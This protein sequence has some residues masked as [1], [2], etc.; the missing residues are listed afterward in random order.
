[1]AAK[2][3]S[4]GAVKFKFTSNYRVREDGSSGAESDVV[5][6]VLSGKIDMAWV[7]ARA[8]PGFDAL[9][10]PLLVDSYDLQATVFDAGVPARMLAD[11]HDAGLVGIAVLPGP[12][13]KVTGVNHPFLVPSDFDGQVVAGDV[14]PLGEATMRALGA[15]PVP[16]AGGQ[17]L[18]GLDAVE[19]HLGAI[20]G[21]GYHAIA[22][23]VTVNLNLWPRPLVVIMNRDV[24]A[25]LTTDQQQALMT[26][27]VQSVSSAMSDSRN[28]DAAVTPAIC[29]AQIAKVEASDSNLSDIQAALR[30]VYDNLE[31]DPRTAAYLAEIR[32][33]KEKLHAP[34]ATVVC[35]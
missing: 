29:K 9:L 20:A 13:R 11:L 28:E 12:M 35:P 26:A 27:G 8:L 4:A 23:S 5:A 34:P 18:D 24:F 25:R 3:T 7:G 16:G 2:Q 15:R 17:S 14:N 32:A 6:D 33:L 31:A 30:P 1:V 21:N 22:N 19:G 10:A